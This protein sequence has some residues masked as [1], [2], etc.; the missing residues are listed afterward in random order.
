MARETIDYGI[1]LGTTNS[2]IAFLAGTTAEVVTNDKGA[3]F[4]P[5]AIWFDKRGTIHIG[6]EA[7]AEY[8][9]RGDTDHGAVEF[10]VHMGERDYR[11][12][13]PRA[14][15]EMS[16][17]DMSSEVL[18]ELKR[19]VF[20]N[21]GETIRAAVVTV[22]AAFELPQ[23][24]ATR[25]AAQ[26]AGLELSPLLQEPVAAAMAYGFQSAA[27][28]AFWLVYDFGGGTFDAAVIRVRDGVIEVVNHAGDNYLGGKNIDWDIVEQLLIPRLQEEYDLSG[29][30]RGGNPKWKAALGKLKYFAEETKIKVS[31]SKEPSEVWI[32]DLCEDDNGKE[33][34]LTYELTPQAIQKLLEPRVRQT[35]ALCRRALEEA[36]LSPG[37]IEKT[38]MVGGSSLFPWLQDQLKAEL[39]TELDLSVDPTTV[40]ARG[41][42]VFAGT[43]RLKLDAGQVEAGTYSVELEYEPVGTDTD[44]D[45]VGKVMAPDGASLDGVGIEI[46][47]ARGQWRSGRIELPANG[48]FLTEIHAEK[49]QRCEFQLL[50]TDAQGTALPCS[51]D[52]FHYTV[53]M[54]ITNAPLTHSFGVA[55]AN[56]RPDWFFEKG[57]PLPASKRNTEHRTAVALKKDSPFSEQNVIRIPFIE[58]EYRDKADRNRLNGQLEIRPDD[59]RVKRDIPLGSDVEITIEIDESRTIK[60]GCFTVRAL[61]S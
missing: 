41:A 12:S 9:T 37:D 10:K 44:P 61:R 58:G 59:P 40:V 49:G 21:K 48:G 13:F 52:R 50:L 55:M 18:K 23:C 27:D 6:Q 1:D 36:R 51:P 45:V 43:Q 11:L 46:T 17:E 3:T 16:P 42:A 19:N 26:A 56:N 4:T 34:D 20:T 25:R 33:I 35:I 15:K 31:R 2:A 39:G 53:G 24:E 28:K 22:P 32:E 29:F 14:K 54:V 60:P 7:K 38:I 5:S 57:T 30:K 47:D 8:F